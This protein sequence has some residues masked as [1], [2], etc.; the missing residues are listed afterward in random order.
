LFR[1]KKLGVVIATGTL[2]LGINM[3]CKTVIIAGDQP[4]LNAL[5]Y[6]QEI[7]RAGRRT[8]DNRGHVVFLGTPCRKVCRLQRTSLS[9]LTGNAIFSPSLVL[10][11]FTRYNAMSTDEERTL[12]AQAMRRIVSHAFRHYR[13]DSIGTLAEADFAQHQLL[14]AMHYLMQPPVKAIM[15]INGSAEATNVCGFL[16]HLYFLEPSNFALTTLLH[17]GFFD[18][19]CRQYP[20]GTPLQDEARNQALLNVLANI[21]Y[22]LEL[23]RVAQARHVEEPGLSSVVLDP[24]PAAMQ[25]HLTEYN[26]WVLR[27]MSS[28]ARRYSA[29][30]TTALPPSWVLPGTTAE[31]AD[32]LKAKAAN[33]Q[34][35]GESHSVIASLQAMRM[36]V[37][38]RSAFIAVSGH[39]DQFQ[40]V[41]DLISCTREGMFFESALI[42]VYGCDYTKNAYL[43]DFYKHGQRRPLVEENGLRDSE[44]YQRIYDFCHALK[45]IKEAMV[46]RVGEGPD[47]AQRQIVADAF[48]VLQDSYT[49]RFEK[50]FKG[51]FAD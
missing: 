36:K 28:C 18:Q 51:K 48:S 16:S 7:G 8:F 45:V 13:T 37:S 3:P 2:A 9:D 39:A 38:A 4:Y 33:H 10:R 15:N 29:L 6:H 5:E 46:R 32:A 24:L 27:L 1:V 47:A 49:D 35:G 44:L 25:A 22:P 42:P 19:L 34:T 30:R 17:G 40:D 20:A 21:L 23:S 50:T 11:F 31:M 41:N 14:F 12:C 26:S 43:V